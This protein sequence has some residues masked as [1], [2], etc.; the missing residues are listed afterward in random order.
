MSAAAIHIHSLA[1]RLGHSEEETLAAA[2]D[3]VGQDEDQPPDIRDA[4]LQGPVAAGAFRDIGTFESILERA[5]WS[6][7]LGSGEP[8]KSPVELELTVLA[9]YRSEDLI[10]G[11]RRSFDIAPDSGT[12]GWTIKPR[13]TGTVQIRSKSE[14]R[15]LHDAYIGYLS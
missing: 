13:S 8:S 7:D 5:G 6:S 12:G 11:A 2:T 1:A 9:S 10:V 15:A 3:L 14:R 4:T